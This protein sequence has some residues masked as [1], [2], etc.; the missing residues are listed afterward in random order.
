MGKF[1]KIVLKNVEFKEMLTKT[2]P[3]NLF[4]VKAFLNPSSCFPDIDS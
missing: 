4:G 3:K 2:S 1:N